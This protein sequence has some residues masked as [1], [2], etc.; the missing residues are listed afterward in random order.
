MKSLY[1]LLYGSSL[2]KQ[3]VIDN[4]SG[5]TLNERWAET[6]VANGGTGSMDDIIDGGFKIVTAAV[7]LG[8]GLQYDFNDKRQYSQTASRLIIMSKSLSSADAQMIVGLA[9]GDGLGTGGTYATMEYD[10]RN[11]DGYT[12]R[13]GDGATST[14]VVGNVAR[15]T[16]WHKHELV[17]R[18]SSVIYYIDGDMDVISTVTLPDESLQPTFRG[19][20]LTTAAK[21]FNYRY[22]EAYN[23]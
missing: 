23:T 12:L 21:T 16:A 19:L 1:E 7:A 4:F 10:T 17:L 2:A 3:R 8:D 5:D 18:S 20:T 9:R 11:T 6:T 13:T 15:D 22:V 14:S